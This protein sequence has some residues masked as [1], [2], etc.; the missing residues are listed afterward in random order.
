MPKYEV[1]FRIVTAYE[2]TIPVEAPNKRAASD[3]AKAEYHDSQN[4]L[5]RNPMSPWGFESTV[6]GT[7]GVDR[8]YRINEVAE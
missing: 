8:A 4:L 3:L 2:M 6:E 5:A 7:G 1:T